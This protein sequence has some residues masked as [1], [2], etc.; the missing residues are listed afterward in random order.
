MENKFLLINKCLQ[1]CLVKR[2]NRQR[3]LRIY[4][5]VLEYI[6]N[7]I[8]LDHHPLML[9]LNVIENLRPSVNL[10]SKKVGGSTYKLP[11]LISEK[12]RFFYGYSFFTS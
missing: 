11:Y 9:I 1:G 10:W 8:P 2:G 4:F 7:R 12:K 3:A 5:G 6:R